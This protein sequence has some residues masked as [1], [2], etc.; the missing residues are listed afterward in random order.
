[1][2]PLP[3]QTAHPPHTVRWGVLGPGR[4]AQRFASCLPAVPGA[5]L[6]AVASRNAERGQAFAA[7][8]GAPGAVR[9]HTRYQA[10]FDDPAVDAIYIASPHSHH[11]EQA[12]DAVLAGKAVLCEKPLAVNEAQARAVFDAAR[13]R[14]VFVMEALWSR[15]LPVYTQVRAWLDAGEIGELRSVASQFG[16]AAPYDPAD[17]LFNPALAGGALL[18]IGVYCL[19]LP[20]WLCGGPLELA[21]AEATLGATGVDESVQAQL[22]SASG[23]TVR[24]EASLRRALPNG[25]RLEGTLGTIEVAAPFWESQ[26]AVLQRTGQPPLRCAAPHDLNGFEYQVREV[27]R[28]LARGAHQSEVMPWADTLS[29]L[30]A[31]DH[32]RQTIGVCY[33]FEV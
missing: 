3:A 5:Q 4:I 7:A 11:A 29:V 14:G 31:M 15:F 23:V 8:H 27:H 9:V 18:D 2:S 12:L 1:M 10:L 22:Q 6:V 20:Q 26:L 13:E 19:T 32:I 21:H 24:F 16:F 17:R 28:C 33:P 30:R 25:L